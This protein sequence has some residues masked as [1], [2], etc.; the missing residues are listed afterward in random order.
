ALVDEL[1]H[2]T[3]AL[4]RLLNTIGE[5][6]Q[7]IVFGAP[8]RRPGP[9][10]PG[11]GATRRAA[12]AVSSAMVLVVVLITALAGCALGPAAGDP[13]TDDLRPASA[14]GA[15]AKMRPAVLVPDVAAPTWMDTPAIFYRL[16]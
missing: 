2:E 6:P 9:S 10:E 7:S 1:S 16:A 15:E 3:R 13:V 14:K 4:D 11:Y 8:P 5:H 12:R